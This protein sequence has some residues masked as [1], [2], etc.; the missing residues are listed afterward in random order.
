[1][2]L[3][4]EKNL[5]KSLFL[6]LLA[7]FGNFVGGTLSC[8]TQYYANNYMIV[9]HLLLFM[10]IYFSN[11]LF[12]D[13]NINPIYGLKISVIIWVIY[14]IFTKQDIIFTIISLILLMFI[15]LI[16]NFQNYY[17]KNNK[18]IS[19]KLLYYRSIVKNLFVI[20]LVIGFFVYLIKQSN[21][22]IA[23]FDITKFIFGIVNC[24]TT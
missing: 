17:E 9:K 4:N 23:D 14:L 8:K 7:V 20:N 15:Y 10:M 16:D 11:N 24:K 12:L 21:E 3:I 19:D 1:M 5:V 13:E 6:L 22:Y 2:L 18:E